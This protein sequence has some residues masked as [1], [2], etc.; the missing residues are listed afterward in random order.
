[1]T[2]PRSQGVGRG[3]A[4]PGHTGSPDASEAE[5]AWIPVS[6]TLALLAVAASASGGRGGRAGRAG[7]SQRDDGLATRLA[8]A[9]DESL[10][11]L[12]A[13]P[14]PRRAVIAAYARLERVLA[15]HGLPRKTSEAPLEYLARMLDGLSVSPRGAQADGSLRKG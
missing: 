5:F 8:A 6:I 12:R 14:D 13:E 9:L 4:R 15:S 10:D 1:M 3:D 2:L 7:S 11:D